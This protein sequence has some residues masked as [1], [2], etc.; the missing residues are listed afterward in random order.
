V[1]TAAQLKDE[2]WCKRVMSNIS[3]YAKDYPMATSKCAVVAADDRFYHQRADFSYEKFDQKKANDVFGTIAEIAL[4]GAA[5]AGGVY[6]AKHNAFPTNTGSY[7]GFGGTSTAGYTPTSGGTLGG[8][9]DADCQRLAESNPQC[10]T[11]VNRVKAFIANI[12]NGQYRESIEG[13]SMMAFC[14]AKASAEAYRACADAVRPI[15]PQ[16]ANKIMQDSNAF[17]DDAAQAA[18]TNQAVITSNWRER[19]RWTG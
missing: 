13:Q 14:G 4:V 3:K 8:G 10:T 1:P 12:Q 16:C 19:C 15:N 17:L 6:L 5:A 9:S 7:G 11:G 18:Q 2:A